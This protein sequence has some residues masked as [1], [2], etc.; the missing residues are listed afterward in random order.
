MKKRMIAVVSYLKMQDSGEPKRVKEQ[1]LIPGDTY[2]TAEDF[3]FKELAK[4]M[5]GEVILDS[6]KRE[7]VEDI[8]IDDEE[9]LEGWYKCKVGVQDPESEKIK[10]ISY[11]YYV[12]AQSVAMATTLLTVRL[13]TGGMSDFEIKSTVLSPIVDVYEF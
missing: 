1:F 9:K 12:N 5:K 2:S 8:F 13:S 4:E 6:L 11:S 10:N 7:Q 3:V